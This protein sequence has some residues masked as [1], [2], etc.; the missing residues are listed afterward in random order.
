MAEDT[1]QPEPVPAAPRP[2]VEVTVRQ[3][4]QSEPV[5][6]T[7]SPDA[8]L[9]RL[10]GEIQGT[11]AGMSGAMERLENE[12]S[13]HTATDANSFALMRADM[14]VL[15]DIVNRIKKPVETFISLRNVIVGMVI[16]LAGVG[17]LFTGLPSLFTGWVSGLFH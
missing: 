4:K 6:F 17:A 2:S 15:T 11:L 7:V 12:F 9:Y 16:F 8:E 1:P 5:K 14:R 13:A 3:N 10:L